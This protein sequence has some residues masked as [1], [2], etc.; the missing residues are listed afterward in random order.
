MND[1][2]SELSE[3][4]PSSLI[5]G[6][7]TADSVAKV[8]LLERVGRVEG[9]LVGGRTCHSGETERCEGPTAE[10]NDVDRTFENKSPSSPTS[11]P[12]IPAHSILLFLSMGVPRPTYFINCQDPRWIELAG[13]GDSL[14]MDLVLGDLPMVGDGVCETNDT[15]RAD[16]EDDGGGEGVECR[17]S[18]TEGS[19][20][21]GG[22]RQD[23]SSSKSL[24]PNCGI[25][26]STTGVATSSGLC[27]C[28]ETDVGWT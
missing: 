16:G 13:T 27:S 11:S 20:E 4:I 12:L 8:R 17:I 2:H 14:D 5:S 10:S 21:G 6:F 25:S 23:K 7:S 1:D 3:P 9:R 28:G 19:G 15:E 24:N 18:E 22:E 26:E